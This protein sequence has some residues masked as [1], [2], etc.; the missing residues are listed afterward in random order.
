V[1]NAPFSTPPAA[2]PPLP[3]PQLVAEPRLVDRPSRLRT[4]P[5]DDDRQKLAQMAALASRLTLESGPAPA[6]PSRIAATDP[7][8]PRTV[9]DSLTVND[10]SGWVPAP[11]YD[12]EHPEELSYRPFPLAPYMTATASPDDT[13]LVRMVHPDPAMTL[14]FLDQAGAMPPMRLRPGQQV[15]QLLWAQQFKGEAVALDLL[16]EPP[17][18]APDALSNR[19]VKTSNSQ[20]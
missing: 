2:E 12:D 13:A 5:T 15:A 4:M 1:P 11:A 10:S 20:H 7:S 19:R 9:G 3:A 17:A 6:R 16:V 8:T 14:E 18:S